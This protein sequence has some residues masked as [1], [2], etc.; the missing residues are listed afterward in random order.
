MLMPKTKKNKSRII[1]PVIVGV[2]IA[3][4][5]L[6][7]SY[8]ER[9]KPVST[10]KE[11]YLFEVESG[12]SMRQ[13]IHTLAKEG[14][15][16]DGFVANIHS[17]VT[18][19]TALK[20]GVFELDKSMSTEEIL[21][22]LIV[23]SLRN[24]KVQLKEND[25]AK[26]MAKTIEEAMGISADTFIALWNNEEFVTEMID[27]YEV[28]T[29]DILK[30]KDKVRV[31]LEGYLYPDTYNFDKSM[32]AKEVTLKILDNTEAK[33]LEIRDKISGYDMSI[34][35]LIKFSSVVMYEAGTGEDQQMVAGVFRN[36]LD[37]DMM[38]QSSVTVCYALYDFDNWKDCESYKNQKI[39]SPYN[40]YVYK[41]LPVGP[42]L[43]PTQK[44][45]L[46]VIDYKHHDYFYFIADVYEGG[47][48]KVYYSKTFKE[49]EKKRL[50]LQK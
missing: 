35:D 23:P 30:E 19:R 4:I 48:G 6:V 39:D 27:K 36:R 15:I 7:Y 17:K 11:P 26:N 47:D 14:V 12:D 43:N 32:S 21:D 42:I 29:S 22:T 18:N 16:R 34:H 46:N 38:L 9:L 41:G 40:T 50:E 31:L 44:A 1:I 45:I 24:A 20:A 37:T 13:A 8:N 5:F 3:I 10:Q 28:L 49:H 25:W 2:V 33:Y